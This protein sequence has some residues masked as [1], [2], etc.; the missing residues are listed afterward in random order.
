[1]LAGGILPVGASILTLIV[2]N[3]HADA[4]AAS[5][6]KHEL[7]RDHA[8][9]VFEYKRSVLERNR[10]ACVRLHGDLRELR[11]ILRDSLSLELYAKQGQTKYSERLNE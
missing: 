6:H 10:A 1:V 8:R 3:R 7:R 4:R 11:S 5:D 2:Q 9:Q